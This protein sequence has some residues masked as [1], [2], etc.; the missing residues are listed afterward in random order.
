MS[1]HVSSIVALPA[2]DRRRILARIHAGPATPSPGF[3]AP[4]VSAPFVLGRL[5]VLHGSELV[6][7]LVSVIYQLVVQ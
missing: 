6:F 2:L 4:V 5:F 1:R 7:D 3:L